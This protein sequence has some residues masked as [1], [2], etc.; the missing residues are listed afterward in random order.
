MAKKRIGKGDRKQSRSSLVSNVLAIVVGLVIIVGVIFAVKMMNFNVPP[1]Q[2]YVKYPHDGQIGAPRKVKLEWGCEDPDGD[3]LTYDLYL[4]EGTPVLVATGITE[5]SYELELLPG[6]VY[7]WKVVAKDGKGGVSESPVWRFSTMENRPPEKPKAISPSPGSTLEST[8]VR[9]VWSSEDPDGDD[10]VYDLYVDGV[11]VAKNLKKPEFTTSVL[12][13]EKHIWRVVAKD[14]FGE[15]SESEWWFY[16]KRQNHPP[17]VEITGIE[18]GEGWIRLFWK[19]SDPDG[20][21]IE[22]KVLI[23][24]SDVGIGNGEKVE[25]DY[26]KH[27]IVVEVSDGEEV[28]SDSTVVVL[29]KPLPPEKPEIIGES[30]VIEGAYSF[31]W[32]ASDP[33]STELT[34]EIYVDGKRISRTKENSLKINLT[35]G[36]HVIKVVALDE[37]GRKS[38]SEMRVKV[39]SPSLRIEVPSEVWRR[40]VEVRWEFPVQAVYTLYLNGKVVYRG[41]GK[42]AVLNLRDGENDLVLE[43]R[44][45]GKTFKVERKVIFRHPYNVLA[46]SKGEGIVL[47]RVGKRLEVLD[48]VGGIDGRKISRE[49]DLAAVLGTDG[50]VYVFGL[51]KDY[52]VILSIIDANARDIAVGDN[53]VYVL[54]DGKLEV[55]DLDGKVV[56]YEEMPNAIS[57]SYQSGK[58]YVG[59]DNGFSILDDSLNTT[60]SFETGEAVKKVIF[61]KNSYYILTESGVRK[62]GGKKLEFPEPVDME[63]MEDEIVLADGEL[64]VVV[65]DRNLDVEYSVEVPKVSKVFVK[66]GEIIAFGRGV[67]R[68]R[69]GEIVEKIGFGKV[70]EDVCGEFLAT[71]E[72]LFA[73]NE[74]IFDFPVDSLD[75]SGKKATFRSG[76]RLYLYDGKVGDLGIEVS[77]FGFWKGVLYAVSSGK[78]LKV[79]RGLEYIDSAETFDNGY[80]STGRTVKNLSGKEFE[81]TGRVLRISAFGDVVAALEK[82]RIEVFRNGRRVGEI[83]GNFDGVEVSKDL[84]IAWKDHEIFAFD[85]SGNEIW[86]APMTSRV[87]NVKFE[88]GKLK[89]ANTENGVVT[90]DPKDGGVLE[91]TLNLICGGGG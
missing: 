56:G 37:G 2:P 28:S 68:I 70:I 29:S 30:R 47:I 20:D 23:D 71:D 45:L 58:L 35:P 51:E 40:K 9:L 42:R 25:L 13:G 91:D 10:V 17:S 33:D 82:G 81:T 53:S 83:D 24:G 57:L 62:L 64:G 78:L 55:Y 15:R 14:S 6:K 16:V 84:L 11:E 88:D 49:G 85:F 69:D 50:S 76:G 4:G 48:T 44:A 41:K 52:A 73:G 65:L 26:G 21:R 5:N 67:Y 60:E 59:K 63:R 90:L 8:T 3:E 66:D 43:A 34:F 72:G 31:S 22:E 32:K 87:G 46:L 86:Y 7:L 74:K 77:D 79:G 18:K 27:E 19:S 12:P 80:Y 1:S 39:V 89:V 54:T 61:L 75:C 38:E 36:E